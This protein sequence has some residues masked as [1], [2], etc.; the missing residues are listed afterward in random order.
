MSRSLNKAT[1][2]GNA[3]SDPE[4]RTTATGARVATVTLATNRRWT[5]A[6]GVHRERTEWHRLVALD[7]LAQVFERNVRKG[8]RLFVAGHLEYRSWDSPR[9]RRQHTTEIVAEDI[10]VLDPDAMPPA[11]FWPDEAEKQAP[12]DAE[13]PF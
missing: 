9:G 4:V 13:L 7:E 2:I 10:L 8:T 11:P 12:R 1:L 3:G 5:D 6:D